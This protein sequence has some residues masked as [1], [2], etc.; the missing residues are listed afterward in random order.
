[1]AKTDHAAL[2]DEA[3]EGLAS[4]RGVENL[5]PSGLDCHPRGTAL[6]IRATSPIAL[7]VC[8][9]CLGAYIQTSDG[10]I[11]GHVLRKNQRK[12]KQCGLVADVSDFLTRNGFPAR[13]CSACRMA[14]AKNKKEAENQAADE[15]VRANIGLMRA[16]LERL[17]RELAE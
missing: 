17:E 3:W 9:K 5:N 1:M 11:Y 13:F 15:H 10:A 6:V 4:R 2:L 16:E 12:C 7:L 8:V 14:W